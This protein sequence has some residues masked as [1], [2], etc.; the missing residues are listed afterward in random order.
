MIASMTSAQA[1]SAAPPVTGLSRLEE[2]LA[3]SPYQ[4]YSYGY[5][6]KSAYRALT[7]RP[8]ADVWRHEP[9][10]ALSLYLHVPFCEFRCGF[11]NLF[12]QSQPEE[13]VVVR[14][15]A[16]L[17]RQAQQVRAALPDARF[18]RAAIGGGTPTFLEAGELEELLTIVRDLGADLV[19]IPSSVEASPATIT[20]EKLRLLRAAGVTRLS[21]GVQTFD[22][23]EAGG[24]GRPQRARAVQAALDAIRSAGFPILNIDLIYGGEGQTTATWLAS[25]EAALAWR[26]EELYLYPLYVRPLTGLGR[27]AHAWDDQRLEAYRAGRDR[28]LTAGYE[29]VSM[30]MFRLPGAAAEGPVYCCQTDGM[31]GLGCG[32]RSYTRQLHYAEAF[33]V[34]QSGVRAILGE[35]LARPAAAFG[36]AAYGIELDHEDQERRF[37]ILS[38]LQSEGLEL[39]AHTRRFGADA[40]RDLFASLPELNLLIE[41][42]LAER[43]PGW[44]RLTARGV[45][46]SDVIGPGLASP[47][48]RQLMDAFACD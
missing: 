16:Q 42:G 22:D 19:S 44:L 27:L 36:Q 40:G 47:R 13:G 34:S 1:I 39:A 8:L 38:L 5:P 15:L 25:I 26:P 10:A 20:A 48:V 32:A 7:P 4:G 37:V 21:L 35:Y 43:T 29:Q 12:T 11:C 41:R 14:Y 45:E 28:L 31:V 18:A 6:H 24:L 30:R 17:R 9:Q 46:L 2:A 33:A 3:G 23:R